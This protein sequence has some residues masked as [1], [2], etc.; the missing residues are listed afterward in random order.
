MA[1]N[2][3]GQQQQKQ[4]H[5]D[6][7]AHYARVGQERQ[8]AE[9]LR[10]VRDAREKMVSGGGGVGP[11]RVESSTSCGTSNPSTEVASLIRQFDEKLTRSQEDNTQLRVFCSHL[12]GLLAANPAPTTGGR[13]RAGVA[14]PTAGFGSRVDAGEVVGCCSADGANG[15]A[16]IKCGPSPPFALR[17]EPPPGGKARR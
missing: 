3:D 2:G 4:P 10:L 15:G 13:A 12:E 8:E 16:G 5:P 1:G 7:I 17:R 14:L 9:I 11:F 6:W